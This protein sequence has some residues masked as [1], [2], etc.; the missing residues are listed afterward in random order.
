MKRIRPSPKL[1]WMLTYGASGPY[2]TAQMLLELG[3]IKADECHST[4]DRATSFTY[5]HLTHRVRQSAIEKF[6]ARA[7]TVH[8]IVQTEIFGYDSITSSSW[9]KHISPIE[10]HPGFQILM[11]HMRDGNPSFSFWFKH[12]DLQRGRTISF[13]FKH[14]DL[15]R[16]RNQSASTTPDDTQAALDSFEH[17]ERCVL[18][19][20][21]RIRI[22]D[23]QDRR[24]EL[25]ELEDI[26]AKGLTASETGGVYFAW[27]DCLRCMKIGA[28]RRSGPGA[29][30][31]ELS[32]YVTVP[33]TLVG[34]IPTPTPFRLESHAHSFFTAARIRRTGAGTE[35]F[36]ISAADVAAYCSGAH[37]AVVV[38]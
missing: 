30:L 13:W 11:E 25:E 8:G 31:Q 14:P 9:Q 1:A 34:W 35:F 5:M 27:S 28:T 26:V 10:E 24:R 12:P 38:A 15:Q 36:N 33:F 6:M 16:G 17:F 29:R 20:L 18:P 2:I 19:A 7:K 23:E 4:N 22:N 37:S 21:E 3:K 32:R